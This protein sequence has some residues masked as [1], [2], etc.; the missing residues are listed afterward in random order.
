MITKS[1][2][3]LL[4]NFSTI[5][6]NIIQINTYIN[7]V[8]IYYKSERK[9]KD[10][11]IKLCLNDEQLNKVKNKRIIIYKNKDYDYAEYL[12]HEKVLYDK[13]INNKY[14]KNNK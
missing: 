11:I 13:N 9:I 4:Q 6:N 12:G 3:K 2:I 1:Q 10:Y 14:N 7:I 8:S 5:R